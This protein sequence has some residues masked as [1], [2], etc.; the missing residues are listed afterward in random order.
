MERKVVITHLDISHDRLEVFKI[1]KRSKLLKNSIV[2]YE[3][4]LRTKK[5]RVIER[6][7]N[8]LRTNKGYFCAFYEDD[9]LKNRTEEKKKVEPFE[10]LDGRMKVAL[11][12]NGETIIED[13]ATVVALSF[14]PNPE[15]LPEVKHRDGN[16]KNNSVSNLYWSN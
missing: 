3:K 2:Q 4:E 14:I 16:I 8:I 10:G 6:H 13:L 7:L 5:I 1:A 11:E 15:N 12:K 9:V